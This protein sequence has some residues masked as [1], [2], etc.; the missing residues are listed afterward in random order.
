MSTVKRILT[1]CGGSS[2]FLGAPALSLDTPSPPPSRRPPGGEEEG[3]M[4]ERGR[5]WRDEGERRGRT[6]KGGRDN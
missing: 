3:R 6:E 4:K 5:G 1:G 2:Y